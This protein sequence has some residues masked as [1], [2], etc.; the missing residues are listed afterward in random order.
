MIRRMQQTAWGRRA[1]ALLLC[2]IASAALRADDQALQQAAV[3]Q[4]GGCSGVCVDP[5]GLVLTAKHCDLR[6]VEPVR[7]GDLEVLATRIYEAVGSE[8]PVV[9]DC[10][11]VGYPFVQVAASVPPPG[12]HVFTMGY[13]HIEG[14]RRFRRQEGTVLSGGE[15][16]FRGEMFL[17]NLTDMSIREGWSGG[18]LFNEAGEVIGLANAS[19]KT[20]SIFISF[21]ATRAA[22]DALHARH[23]QKLLL[24]VVTDLYSRDCLRFLAD[25]ASDEKFRGTL[26]KHFKIVVV[27]VAHQTGHLRQTEVS[28]VPAFIV[29]DAATV[30]GYSGKSQ[31]LQLLLQAAAQTPRTTGNSRR[32]EAGEW[33]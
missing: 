27:D 28:D 8:G 15:F 3:V 18:P 24:R 33:H 17:G 19:D 22:Y 7:F 4:I 23:P 5:D 21:A 9:Y 25:Y 1:A 16:R 6:D 13:P 2:L 32:E 10:P 14:A 11:G 20:G 31:L 26:Q 29:G 12:S 30:A